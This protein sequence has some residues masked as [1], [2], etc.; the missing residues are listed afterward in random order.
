MKI[1]GNGNGN[2]G[3]TAYEIHENNDA[4]DIE[5]TSGGIYTYHRVN[6]GDIHFAVICELANA[7]A[8][9]N[10]YLNRLRKQKFNGRLNGTAPTE[11]NMQNVNANQVLSVLAELKTNFDISIKVWS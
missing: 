8:G 1:Y 9:L 10:G 5:F 3:I 11:I 2:S 7:G 6:I 4:I